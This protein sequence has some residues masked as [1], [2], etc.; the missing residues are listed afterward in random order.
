MAI[1]DN[2]DH[3][4]GYGNAKKTSPAPDLLEFPPRCSTRS[5]QH[6]PAENPD[7]GCRSVA[8]EGH[9]LFAETAASRHCA[10]KSLQPIFYPGRS[11]G[12]LGWLRGNPMLALIHS[13]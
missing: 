12:F 9:N 3:S 7:P 8:G 4:V 2:R 10:S 1:N 11:V 13:C 6:D 5:N